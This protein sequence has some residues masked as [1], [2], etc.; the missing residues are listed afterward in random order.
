L[1]AKAAIKFN[2]PLAVAVAALLSHFPTLHQVDSHP[3]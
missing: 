3:R 1:E 2:L